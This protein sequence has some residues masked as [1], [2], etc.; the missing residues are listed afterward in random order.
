[1]EE[2]LEKLDDVED[3]DDVKKI[4]KEVLNRDLT[5]EELLAIENE[6]D[7]AIENLIKEIV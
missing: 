2:I 5:D 7:N 4:V 1:M 3:I 6:E